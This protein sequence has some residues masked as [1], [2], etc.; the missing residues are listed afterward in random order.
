MCPH[1]STT[2]LSSAEHQAVRVW[3]VC[4][5]LA[6]TFGGI[7]AACAQLTNHLARAGAG[8]VV[9]SLVDDHGP[10]WPLDPGVVAVSSSAAWPDR[11]GYSRGLT[12]QMQA[13][14]PPD[15]VHIHG[16]WRLH[17]VQAARS[18][19]RAAVPVIVT[20]HGMLHPPALRQRGAF[21]RAARWIFQDEVLRTARCLHAT[22]KE[23]A[24]EIRSLGFS[25][26]IAIIPWGVDMPA[27]ER[28]DRP[29][30]GGPAD[31]RTDAPHVLLFLGRLHPTK[32]LETLL[33]AW[34]R[35]FR[36]FPSWRLVLA[37]YDEGHYKAVLTA[38]AGELGL[39]DSLSFAGPVE[40]AAREQLLTGASLLV[41]PS[42]SENF[43]FVV[44]EALARGVPVITTEGAPWS[45]LHAEACGWWIR[46]GDAPL[47]AALEDAFSR[48]P[49][50][51]RAM[52]ERGMRF[53]RAH[54]TWE[55]VTASML[56]LYAWAR[57]AAPEP[58]FI[59]H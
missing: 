51:L 17:L 2:P 49:D 21:K 29:S 55:T 12:A 46:V 52:G 11:L 43:G 4:S 5:S 6:V 57:G 35:V 16:L 25:Q 41:L 27:E 38:L 7:S 26:P 22:A 15:L 9:I 13:L 19:G 10:A 40:G 36:R 56:D 48:P 28:A 44:P 47:A 54:F 1:P 14:T 18:A 34:A 39:D 30:P 33:R 20:V 31:G 23:E 37:G 3:Q 45:S 42:P 58:S 32:G 59:Q 24:D 50:E 53:A 8:V